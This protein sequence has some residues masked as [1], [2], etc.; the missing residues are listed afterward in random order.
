RGN[1]PTSLNISNSSFTNTGLNGKLIEISDDS[2][3]YKAGS[4][5]FNSSRF[6]ES[7][8]ADS[9]ADENEIWFMN[10]IEFDSSGNNELLN[11]H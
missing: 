7:L 8:N 9:I 3:G 4:I 2:Y 11:S 10:C 5:V 6:P 1:G